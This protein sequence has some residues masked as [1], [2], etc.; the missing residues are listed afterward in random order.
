[1]RD[2]SGRAVRSR[3]VVLDVSE[4]KRWEERQQLLIHELNHRVK[5]TL[6]TVQSIANQS[7]R[8]AATP[9][10]A[11][12][13]IEGRLIALSRAHD[14]LTR[15]GWEGAAL[16]EIVGQA[17]EPF[18]GRGEGRFAVEG[19]D[20]RLAPRSALALAMALQELAT[21]A[22]KYGSLSNET[23]QVAIT[24]QVDGP[25]GLLRFVWTE[26]GGPP[27]RAPSRRGFGSRLIERSLASDLGGRADLQFHPGGVVCSIE[28][29]VQSA[30]G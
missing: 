20:L 21:N 6:A 27:V 17:I 5:N 10:Q 24:W 16:R 30:L 19:A 11:R 28:A 1:V 26:S 4:R 18:R 8:N 15:E 25:S 3:G 14:V 23:G 9:D 29:P 2:Q 7:L 13:D 22:V 12:G